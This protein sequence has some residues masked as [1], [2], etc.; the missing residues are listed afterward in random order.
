M[1]ERGKNGKLLRLFI[2]LGVI[3]LG[4]LIALSAESWWSERTD[5]GLER[6][7]LRDLHGEML[8]ADSVLAFAIAVDSGMAAEVEELARVLSDDNPPPSDS[9]WIQGLYN[10]AFKEASLEVG[11]LLALFEPGHIRLIRS[12]AIRRELGSLNA[13]LMS[14]LPIRRSLEELLY[15]Q[16]QDTRRE[17]YLATNQGVAALSSLRASAEYRAVVDARALFLQA[18]LYYNRELLEGVQS[19]ISVLSEAVE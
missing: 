14:H 7:Y 4:V 10:V 2:E 5:R 11:T 1:F 3:I 9:T 19:L 12:R 17:I 16:Y 18:R 8:R 6:E 13:V 15:S